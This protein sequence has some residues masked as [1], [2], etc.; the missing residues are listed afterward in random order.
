MPFANR[1][2]PNARSQFP[3]G[4]ML[5]SRELGGVCH[6]QGESDA[7]DG[8]PFRLPMSS[9]AGLRTTDC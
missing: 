7:P 9:S 1:R 3:V 4:D 5:Q 2:P 8:E 6:D